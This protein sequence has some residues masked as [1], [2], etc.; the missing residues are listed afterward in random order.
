MKLPR[1]DKVLAAILL[2]SFIEGLSTCDWLI[3]KGMNLL[4]QREPVR[5]TGFCQPNLP[6]GHLNCCEI[7]AS[8]IQRISKLET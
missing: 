2:P 6:V 1:E 5:E 7:A 3:V 8:L 4:R